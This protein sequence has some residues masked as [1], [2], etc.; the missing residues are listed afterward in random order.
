M[1]AVVGAGLAGLTCAKMLHEAAEEFV[2][3][4]A[5][6][7][8]GGRVRHVRK[9]G[10]T[11]DRGF[12]VFPD[13]YAAMR[14][15]VNIPALQPRYFDSGALMWEDGEFFAVR[16]PMRHPGA[17][18]SDLGTS[19]FRF[20][21]KVKLTSLVS[22]L[23][24]SSDAELLEKCAAPDDEST[25]AYLARLGF[26]E[27]FLRR[28]AQPFF[29]GVFIDNDL[30]TSKGLFWFYLKKLATGRTFIP[31]GGVGDLPA[32]MAAGLPGERLR[33]GTSVEALE[34]TDRRVTALR[35]AGG[36]RLPV[37][38]V[39]LATDEPSTC[40]I[41]GL[42]STGRGH[43]S[44]YVVYLVSDVP[45]LPDKLIVLPAGDRRL[46]RHFTQVTN[47]AP[48][49]AP[50]GQH[51]LSATVLNE[52]GLNES[53][54]AE[55]TIAEISTVFPAARGKLRMLARIPVPYATLSQPPGFAARRILHS[56]YPNLHL[57]GDQVSSSSFE[58][59]MRSGETAALTLLE[60]PL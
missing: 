27:E 12:Q 36:E 52:Q 51:L 30:Q 41:L 6:T 35:L 42:A 18:F 48:E 21:D 60:R 10:F 39:V 33:L 45:L 20:T 47:I 57:A 59:A 31:A 3:L 32:Q 5:A 53:A 16:S 38:R 22:S 26:S 58:A 43:T 24:L 49:Y 4:E 55:A 23:I 25:S 29:G 14:R 13:S 37:T 7:E 8:P 1:I 50:D 56:P 17:I 54:L 9:D 19:A 28:F 11:L 15:H 34:T 46:V 2:V 44:V 40:R